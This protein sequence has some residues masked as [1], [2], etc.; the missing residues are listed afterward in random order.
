[1]SDFFWQSEHK[2]NI[3]NYYNGNNKATKTITFRNPTLN[4]RKQLCCL[5]RIKLE[6]IA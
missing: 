6:F 3:G 5:T 4:G 1:M 2:H